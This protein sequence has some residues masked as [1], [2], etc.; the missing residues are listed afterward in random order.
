MV[1]AEEKVLK[2]I[3]KPSPIESL[4]KQTTGIK[5]QC[6]KNLCVLKSTNFQVIH[7]L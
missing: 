2:I 5:K 7:T 4:F 6:I 1:H 3:R